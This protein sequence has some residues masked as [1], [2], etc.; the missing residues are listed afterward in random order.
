MTIRVVLLRGINVGGHNKLPMAELRQIAEAVGLVEPEIYV[1]SGNMV[2][3][4][5]LDEAGLAESLQTAIEDR[6]GFEVSVVSRTAGEFLDSASSHPFSA[7]GLDDRYLQVA[8]LGRAPD[9]EV[10]TLIEAAD[11]EPDRFEAHGR[12]IYLAYP[13]G[14]GR[15]KLSHTLLERKLGVTVTARN[16]RTVTRLAAMVDARGS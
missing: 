7:L 3:G 10:D 16:W 9:E 13:N 14:S 8:F 5:D 4:T 1:Q 6:F 11:Y 15:S 12:E 2:V